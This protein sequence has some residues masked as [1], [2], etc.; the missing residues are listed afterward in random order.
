MHGKLLVGVKFI[1]RKV[2]FPDCIL[3]RNELD[4]ML[5]WLGWATAAYENDTPSLASTMKVLP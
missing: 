1:V 5:E 2:I 4:D 3:R